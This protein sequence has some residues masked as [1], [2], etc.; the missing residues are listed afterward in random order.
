MSRAYY[1]SKNRKKSNRWEGW[2]FRDIWKR[3]EKKLGVGKSATIAGKKLQR[4]GLG[5]K[6]SS[7][8]KEELWRS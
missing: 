1:W 5:S 2:K 3:E 7:S 6:G 4:R 8:K